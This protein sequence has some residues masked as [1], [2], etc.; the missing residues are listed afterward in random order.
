MDESSNNIFQ[1]GKK[2]PKG[3]KVL[4]VRDFTTVKSGGTPSTFIKEYWDGGDTPWINSGEVQDKKITKPSK[5]ITKKGLQ[6]SAAKL[7]PKNTI[8]M[9]L[10][11]V[12]TGK[13]GLLTFESSTNQSI[14]GIFPSV[15]HDQEFLFYSLIYLRDQILK[16]ST[17]SAQPHI[18]QKI[19][20]SIVVPLPPLPEQQ[21]ISTF[22]SRID[23][24]IDK[25]DKIIEKTDLLKKTLIQILTTKGI[26][27]RKFKTVNI[28]KRFLNMEIPEKWSIKNFRNVLTVQDNY[29]DLIDS[30]KYTRITVKRRHEGVILRD[31]VYGKQILT[32]NQYKVRAGDFIIS[33]RQIVHNAC[34]LIP[35]EFNNAVV[36]NEYSLFSG[37]D[38]LDIRY[39]DWFSQ[40]NLFKQTII[41]TTQGVDIEKYIFLLDEWQDLKMPLPTREEQKRIVTILSNIDNKLAEHIKYRNQLANLKNGLMQKLLTGQIQVKV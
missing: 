27:S 14:S 39:M 19:V 38:E 21:K 37:S 11:G 26:G 9:A 25:T 8:V 6:N 22:L 5:Y 17:G 32:K 41:I 33:R 7:F 40:S 10:T 20:E 13:V 36:S 15:N 35:S 30:E 2:I 24:C 12:T 1:N 23:D 29:I 18:N 31:I 16:H 3:W 4:S 34:G 28:G